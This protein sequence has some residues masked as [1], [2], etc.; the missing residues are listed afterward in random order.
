VVSG[1]A[2]EE[3]SRRPDREQP[4]S[5]EVAGEGIR[6]VAY[7]WAGDSPAL[8]FAHATSFHARC[9]D[10]VIRRLPGYRALAL[11]LRG[12]G[13]ADKP[14]VGEDGEAYRWSHFGRDVSAAV[15]ELGLRGAIGIGHS[16]GG[17]S[18]VRAAAA[19]P[20]RFAA[21][22]LVDPVI[23][24]QFEI[25]GSEDGGP[26]TFVSRR[27]DQWSSPDEMFERFSAREPHASWEPQVL[28][29]YCEY[30][31]LPDPSGDGFHLACP[32]MVEAMTYVRGEHD[33]SEEAAGLDIPV[34]VL[35]ARPRDPADPAAAFSGSPAAP[36]LASWFPRGEDVY[37]PEHSHFIPMEAPALVA[38]HLHELIDRA[39]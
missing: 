12:H 18:V 39:L 5:F 3:R 8:F 22:L 9:W 24:K 10:E 26:P 28:R 21:L 2:P 14:A 7:E 31:L 30:G 37:L 17:N 19:E 35:R 15:A 27:R 1:A 16:M 38:R 13:R 20:G 29:D 11:D 25:P 34:R 4:R 32:P 33:L 6:Q 23:T 36:D